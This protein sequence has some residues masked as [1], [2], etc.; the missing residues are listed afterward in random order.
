MAKSREELVRILKSNLKAFNNYRQETN[1]EPIDLSGADLTGTNLCRANLEN[2]SLKDAELNFAY[3]HS[4]ILRNA[5]LTDLS[6]GRADM[7][8]ADLSGAKMTNA[9]LANTILYGA[10]MSKVNANNISLEGAKVRETNFT[11]ANLTNGNLSNLD[12]NGVNFDRTIIKGVDF[13]SANLAN[14]VNLNTAIYDETTIWP[15]DASNLPEGFTPG[16]GISGQLTDDSDFNTDFGPG[17]MPDTQDFEFL[18]MPGKPHEDTDVPIGEMTTR[19]GSPFN[20]DDEIPPEDNFEAPP[21]FESFT[22]NQFLDTPGHPTEPEI[23]EFESFDQGLPG[24]SPAQTDDFQQIEPGLA[25]PEDDDLADPEAFGKLEEIDEFTAS[26]EELSQQTGDRTLGQLGSFTDQDFPVQSSDVPENMKPAQDLL[27]GLETEDHHLPAAKEFQPQQHKETPPPHTQHPPK[28]IPPEHPAEEPMPT[29]QAQSVMRLLTGMSKKIESLESEQRSQ[30][31]M[32]AHLKGNIR[33]NIQQQVTSKIIDMAEENKNLFSRL[34]S[35]FDIIAQADPLDQLDSLLG[36]L[37]DSIRSEQESIESKI[38]DLSTVLDSTVALIE[39]DS[40]AKG[41]VDFTSLVNNFHQM[42]SNLESNVREDQESISHKIDDVATII[43]GF[44]L[45]LENIQGEIKQDTAE[46]ISKISQNINSVDTNVN[47]I[48]DTINNI[49]NTVGTLIELGQDNTAESQIYEAFYDFEF[50]MQLELEK[51]QNKLSH[52]EELFEK[53]YDKLN[54]LG[55]K[56]SGLEDN[57]I[58]KMLETF[59]NQLFTEIQQTEQRTNRLR[60]VVDDMVIQLESLFNMQISRLQ[61]TLRSDISSLDLKFNTLDQKVERLL[62]YNIENILD[63][64]T[65]N[66]NHKIEHL[67]TELKDVQGQVEQSNGYLNLIS[68]KINDLGT[69]LEKFSTDSKIDDEL[70]SVFEHLLFQVN[71][72]ASNNQESSSKLT[73]KFEDLEMELHMTLKD[74]D[75]RISKINSMIRNVYKGLDSI[76]DLITE[77]SKGHR[78]SPEKARRTLA[79]RTK[80]LELDTEDDDNL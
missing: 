41:D 78:S 30:R 6:V 5:D 70:R 37:A 61:E 38:I 9:D 31:E 29:A 43:E 76:T 65:Q 8:E 3:L 4:S 16:K 26:F 18:D 15:A 20:G 73:K 47:T 17:V 54:L 2:A 21:S 48:Q 67:H 23:S 46:K 32:I 36:E 35:K 80:D 49:N 58:P 66:F 62:S 10:N 13:N 40:M 19:L 79:T 55:E 69:K 44:S 7:T 33:D 27:G 52:L 77:S 74:M 71:E 12:L 51:S 64:E 59:R 63:K 11:G 22:S 42:L 75:R 60:E 14:A 57:N 50:R 53:A 25:M 24:M 1:N 56:T 39:S 72:Y 45:I 28:K 34:E 68:G